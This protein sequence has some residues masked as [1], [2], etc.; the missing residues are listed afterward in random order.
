MAIFPTGMKK[1][2]FGWVASELA[3]RVHCALGN[4][5]GLFEKVFASG[6]GDL[7]SKLG[8]VDACAP[9]DFIGHPVAHAREIALVE[10]EGRWVVYVQ[11]N[12]E[13]FERRDLTLGFR[14]GDWWQVLGGLSPGEW[15]VTEGAYAVRLATVSGEI[16]HGHAH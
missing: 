12:G 5:D 10:E 14:D 1:P 15:I 8:R 13:T 9:E 2:A 4:K 16:G 7:S 6:L 3:Y 11:L